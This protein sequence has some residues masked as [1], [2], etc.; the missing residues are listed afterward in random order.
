VVLIFTRYRRGVSK[1]SQ[2]QPSTWVRSASEKR[3][4]AKAV[5]YGI[6]FQMTADS[7]PKP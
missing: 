6:L 1:M 2:I 4:K 5:N 7:L 3:D